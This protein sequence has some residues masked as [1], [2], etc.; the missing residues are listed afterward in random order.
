MTPARPRRPVGPSGEPVPPGAP[1]PV[2]VAGTAGRET[3]DLNEVHLSGAVTGPPKAVHDRDAGLRVSF[4]LAVPNLPGHDGAG[5]L[6]ID[7]VCWGEPAVLVAGTV[8][9]GDRVRITGRL[10]RHEWN[11]HGEPVRARY[12]IVAATVVALPSPR[13]DPAAQPAAPAVAHP[14]PRPGWAGERS[15]VPTVRPYGATGPGC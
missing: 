8:Q 3:V 9:A 15:R 14:H 2:P 6:L 12:E 1:V 7:V 5:R 10:C 11:S 13:G 4:G